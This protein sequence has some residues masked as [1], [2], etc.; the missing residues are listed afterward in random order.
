[1]ANRPGNVTNPSGKGGFKDNPQNIGTGAWKKEY[2][3][4]YQYNRFMNM[5]SDELLVLAKQWRIMQLN[6]TE[7]SDPLYK[8]KFPHT[9]VE[10]MCLRRVLA[11]M[12]SLPDV[13]EINDRVEGRP[14][15][16]IEAKIENDF[17]NYSDEALEK[18]ARSHERT[19]P[20]SQSS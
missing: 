17:A 11:S 18:L 10:E 12:K 9:V 4:S 2:V 7:V 8:G 14:M 15:Q 1:M 16:K 3:P 20:R 13:K 19:N 5:D 6:E